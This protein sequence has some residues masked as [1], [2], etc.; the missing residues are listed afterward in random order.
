MNAGAIEG[1]PRRWHKLG[2]ASLILVICGLELRA[3]LGPHEDWPFTSA[4]MFARYHARRDPL[5]E[6]S[7]WIEPLGGQL[8]ELEPGPHLGLGELGFR[9]QFF[10]RYYGSTDPAHPSGHHSQD[11]EARFRTRLGQWMKL[12]SSAYVRRTGIPLRSIRLE[13]RR[14]SKAGVERRP[15]AHFDVS[16]RLL[17]LLPWRG[18]KQ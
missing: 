7:I 6:L 14:H 3:I 18:Q 8:V 13:V 17:T 11:D 4:P 12:V 10:A 16:S 15:L 5:F 2:A 1:E 9:R